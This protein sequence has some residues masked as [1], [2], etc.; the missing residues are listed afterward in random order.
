MSER[1]VLAT[2]IKDQDSRE[3]VN[4]TLFRNTN[5]PRS[6]NNKTFL[7]RWVIDGEVRSR[8]RV[9]CVCF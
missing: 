2:S 1:G 9:S 5:T 3:T 7:L 6:S 4:D 8:E